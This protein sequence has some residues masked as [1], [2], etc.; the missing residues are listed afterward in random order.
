MGVVGMFDTEPL[1][2]EPEET[3]KATEPEVVE[4]DMSMFFK[5]PEEVES[6]SKN[7]AT[8]EVAAQGTTLEE[9]SPEVEE[10]IPEVEDDVVETIPEIVIAPAA[11]PK[12]KPAAELAQPEAPLR[13][14]RR[15]SRINYAELNDGIE[16]N[17]IRA[18][19]AGE[20]AYVEPKRSPRRSP[21]K[22]AN[23]APPTS[24]ASLSSAVASAPTVDRK[25]LDV[26]TDSRLNINVFRAERRRESC[27]AFRKV[28]R[29]TCSRRNHP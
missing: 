9:S 2:E 24:K 23:P 7:E 26:G 28:R 18:E 12:A 8:E 20:E 19:K 11:A 15:G 29:V 1:T 17:P 14:S 6:A 27:R 25:L 5:K 16:E 22:K 10:T 3:V 21:R 13:R 4:E